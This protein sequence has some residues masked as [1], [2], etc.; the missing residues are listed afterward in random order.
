MKQKLSTSHTVN[1][2]TVS[3]S[4]HKFLFELLSQRKS[5]ENISH[6]KMPTFEEHVKFVSSA[7]YSKWYIVRLNS[8]KIG[9]VY[10]THQNEIGIHV[11]EEVR[12]KDVAKQ[13]LELI[14]KKNP[15]SRYLANI[16][17][18]NKRSIKFFTKNGFKLIQYTYELI[19]INSKN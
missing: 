19:P 1:L 18:K 12:G 8:T 6:K 13:A 10:L 4:D 2:K 14:M 11:I 17:P 16:N 5:Y 3:S 15:K 7:P 9:T